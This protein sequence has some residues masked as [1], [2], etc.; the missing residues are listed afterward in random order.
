MKGSERIMV[1]EDETVTELEK[2]GEKD[3][4]Q[5]NVLTD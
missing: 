3:R 2:L 5:V 1:I 4:E